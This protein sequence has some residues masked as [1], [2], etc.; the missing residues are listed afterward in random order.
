MHELGSGFMAHIGTFDSAN[1]NVRLAMK[2]G[3][4]G[5]DYLDSRLS[6]SWAS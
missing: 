5:E 2:G 1:A 3:Q 6:G 4:K